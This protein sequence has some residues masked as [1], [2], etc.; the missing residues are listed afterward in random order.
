MDFSQQHKI[1]SC[2]PPQ[3]RNGECRKANCQSKNQQNSNKNFTPYQFQ[4]HA[5]HQKLQQHHHQNLQ[6]QQQKQQHHIDSM[7]SFLQHQFEQPYTYNTPTMP[8]SRSFCLTQP[9]QFFTKQ[10]QDQL[11]GECPPPSAIDDFDIEYFQCTPQPAQPPRMPKSKI[12]TQFKPLMDSM[13]RFNQKPEMPKNKSNGFGEPANHQTFFYEYTDEHDDYVGGGAKQCDE[14][15][16]KN[17]NKRYKSY[18][19]II[20]IPN[21]VKI[22]TEIKKEDNYGEDNFCVKKSDKKQ[23]DKWVNKKIEITLNDDDDDVEEE[24]EDNEH[25]RDDDDDGDDC[26]DEYD[27]EEIPTN[28]KNKKR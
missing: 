18:T 26:C 16:E 9:N 14:R 10:C 12:S 23:D 17:A 21:G 19:K 13:R 7:G 15:D 6:R 20:S 11:S 24:E 5:Q 3:S 4:M 22:V 1:N 25:N 28:N 27:E 8:T 2:A